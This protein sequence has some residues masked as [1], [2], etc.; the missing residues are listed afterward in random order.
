M[1]V[2]CYL[3]G[4]ACEAA[5]V[6]LGLPVGTVKSR[7]A[8]GRDRLRGRLIRRGL[9]PSAGL[10]AT[11]LA[12]ESAPAAV[13]AMVAR[14]TARIA[15]GLA[16]G[17]AAS[18]G[19][20]PAS[21]SAIA[22]R[23]LM[24]MSLGRLLRYAGLV[25]ALAAPIGIAA[26]AQRSPAD[27]TRRNPRETRAAPRIEAPN[28]VRPELVLEEALQAAERIERPWMKAKA[29][30]DIAAD[31]ARVGQIER[32]R[33]TFARVAEIIEKMGDDPT[34]IRNVAYQRAAVLSWQA[35]A[36]A[37]AGDRAQAAATIVRMLE[38]VRKIDNPGLG[39][40]LLLH[41]AT[42]QAQAGYPQ[43]ALDLVRAM[44]DRR[45]DMRAY[46]LTEIAREQARAGDLPGARA[47]MARADAEAARAE[48]ERKP[49]RQGRLERRP[50][51]QR[52]SLDPLDP[53]RL[54]QVRGLAPLAAAEAKAGELD[55]AR[56]T[57]RRARAVAGRIGKESQPTPMA[58]IAMAQRET[59]DR[60]AADATLGLALK[61]AEA[62]DDPDRRV[63]NLA[64][65]AIVQADWG[66]RAAARQT[67]EKAIRVK[68]VA[69]GGNS[70]VQ[71]VVSSAWYK[72]GDWELG[73][74]FALGI[75]DEWLRPI[76]LEGLS[77]EQAKAGEARAAM[78]WAEAQADPLIRTRSLLGIV[79]G[80]IEPK[81]PTPGK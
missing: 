24:S 53:M 15:T 14:S 10:L 9:A 44:D 43:G 62:L 20:V 71:Q 29:L 46:A 33:A 21:V 30:A 79:R 25:L 37:V 64:R 35:R 59:G 50:K 67:L 61:I 74:R 18:L 5:A 28:P 58:E 81:D 7:L 40:S 77:Y 23:I 39:Q 38:W 22:R 17:E 2:L 75:N 72:V 27:P 4:L 80:I 49:E 3:E 52:A 70:P 1:I 57:I 54:A 69:P 56:A 41:A 12:A 13:P 42:E 60:D 51:A 11:L 36:Q 78:E 48:K 47:T 76:H 19:A 55:A 8:R 31:Q 63:E 6:R 16:A 66:D 32:S 73:R 45:P 26:M 68:E 34:L 65:V